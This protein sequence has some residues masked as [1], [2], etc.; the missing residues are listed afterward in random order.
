MMLDHDIVAVSA[1]TISPCLKADVLIQNWKGKP[2]NKGASF[3]QLLASSPTPACGHLHFHI[4]RTLYTL[5]SLLD[6]YCRFFRF[7]PAIGYIISPRQASRQR[8]GPMFAT[9]D[10]KVT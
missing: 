9:S 4:N 5:C 3:V 1:S 8:K 10:E 2:S 7:L 6:G